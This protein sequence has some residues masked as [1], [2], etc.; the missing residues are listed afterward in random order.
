MEET[1]IEKR[2][3]GRPRTK[4]PV[5]PTVV[6]VPGKRGRPKKDPSELK[7]AKKINEGKRGRPRRETPKEEEITYNSPKIEIKVAL[8]KTYLGISGRDLDKDQKEKYYTLI[9]ATPLEDFTGRGFDIFKELLN[10]I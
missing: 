3:R 6:K 7:S 8:G 10:K 1:I 5:D 9:R 2:K 4:P